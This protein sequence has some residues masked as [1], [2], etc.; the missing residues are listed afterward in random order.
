VH[1]SRVHLRCGID[2]RST[3]LAIDDDGYRQ[4]L[5]ALI[6]GCQYR[7][8]LSVSWNVMSMRRTDKHCGA[9]LVAAPATLRRLSPLLSSPPPCASS[10][11]PSAPAS[12][13][14]AFILARPRPSAPRSTVCR[15][16]QPFHLSA[17]SSPLYNVRVQIH[18]PPP[19]YYH[20]PYY[21]QP[22]LLLSNSIRGASALASSDSVLTR[23]AGILRFHQLPLPHSG[24]RP[25][26]C[27]L[28]DLLSPSSLNPLPRSDPAFIYYR[29]LK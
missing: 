18:G 27:Y 21:Q 16:L 28:A 9:R 29:F 17:I 5:Y 4:K 12:L 14:L 15:H 3:L 26:S 25:T 6:Y 11:Y 13:P 8:V 20:R 23:R 19:L 22:S 24:C 7:R 1:Q 2:A 10:S